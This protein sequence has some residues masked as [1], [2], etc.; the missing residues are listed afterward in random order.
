MEMGRP[1]TLWTGC[2]I[3]SIS[4]FISHTLT[5]Q[6]ATVNRQAAGQSIASAFG[7]AHRTR[8]KGAFRVPEGSNML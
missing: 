8:A 6:G 3:G 4:T 7:A 1:T 2:C 5:R